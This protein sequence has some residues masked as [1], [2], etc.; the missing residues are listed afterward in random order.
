MAII[1]GTLMI[2]YSFLLLLL[3]L[4]SGAQVTLHPGDNIPRIVNSKPEGTT[5]IFTPGAYHLSEPILPKNNDQFIGE[6]A[7][8]PP[9]TSCPAI[10]TGAVVIGSSAKFDG[11]IY[12]V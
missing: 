1:A 11:S 12:H 5:F 10:L 6:I 9:K 3:G 8:S 4:T 7:C 2:R